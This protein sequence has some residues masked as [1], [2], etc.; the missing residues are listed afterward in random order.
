MKNR[1]WR[2]VVAIGIGAISAIATALLLWLTPS[3]VAHHPISGYL[4]DNLG[5][6][7]ALWTIFWW[8]VLTPGT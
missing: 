1:F 3:I 4:W 7:W 8:A 6:F 5:I 2:A